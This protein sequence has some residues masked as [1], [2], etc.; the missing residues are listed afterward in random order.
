MLIG[1]AQISRG[2]I[3]LILVSVI[4]LKRVFGGTAN[5]G[6]S[7]NGSLI[8]YEGR[9]EGVT[10]GFHLGGVVVLAAGH[11]GSLAVSLISLS[12]SL[13]LRAERC[14][15]CEIGLSEPISLNNLD[16]G[17]SIFGG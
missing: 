12:T 15:I 4:S 6:V 16:S 13:V 3:F 1:L 14:A 11:V 7:S 10:D 17:G 9:C 5:I 8:N 2:S